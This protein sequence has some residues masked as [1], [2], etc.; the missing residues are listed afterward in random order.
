MWEVT[1][2]DAQ[3]KR[4]RCKSFITPS[5][6]CRNDEFSENIIAEELQKGYMYKNVL[7][8]SMVKVAN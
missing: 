4:I 7:R 8:H 1:P 5:D 2:M 3:G 6:A